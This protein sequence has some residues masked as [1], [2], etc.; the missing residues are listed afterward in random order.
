MMAGKETITVGIF[1]DLR[2]ETVNLQRLLAISAVFSGLLISL[3][4]TET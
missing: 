4:S 2:S 1:E 3:L